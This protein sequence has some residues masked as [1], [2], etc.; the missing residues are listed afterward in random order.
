MATR[1]CTLGETDSEYRAEHVQSPVPNVRCNI[2]LSGQ[3]MD[4]EHLL[5][6]F[7]TV[8]RGIVQQAG[9]AWFPCEDLKLS[10]T[11][12]IPQS[13]EPHLWF[14]A[15]AGREGSWPMELPNPR[16]LLR[17]VTLRTF[18]RMRDQAL[19]PHLWGTLNPDWQSGLRWL[20]LSENIERRFLGRDHRNL[21]DKFFFFFSNAARTITALTV[22]R[23]GRKL[24]HLGNVGSHSKQHKNKTQPKT[25]KTKHNRPKASQ[26]ARTKV[27][28]CET[29]GNATLKLSRVLLQE[30]V[31]NNIRRHIQ[32]CSVPTTCCASLTHLEAFSKRWLP[33][34]QDWF[35]P[36]DR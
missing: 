17:P 18:S 2:K 29:C 19:S 36:F 11:V 9:G 16:P 27:K 12:L 3:S 20:R 30:I 13:S 25:N 34:A 7:P 28:R 32:N 6:R 4:V 35:H 5:Q 1:L 24:R 8:L 23:S 26:K 21:V 31:P 15:I 14:S 10:I 22:M 33:P